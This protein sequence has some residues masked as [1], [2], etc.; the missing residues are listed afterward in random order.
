MDRFVMQVLKQELAPGANLT[1]M[2]QLAEEFSH[3][4]QSNVVAEAK[5]L[6]S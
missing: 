4:F 5:E 2:D 1:D 3:F 6:Q